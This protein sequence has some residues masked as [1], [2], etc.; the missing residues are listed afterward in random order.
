MNT[1]Q[2]ELTI[3]ALE[4]AREALAGELGQSEVK[5]AILTIRLRLT[6]LKS[7][8]AESDTQEQIKL[9]A[10]IEALQMAEGAISDPR[11]TDL[12]RTLAFN[13][14]E[15]RIWQLRRETRLSQGA[16]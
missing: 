16:A 1:R 10:L 7:D 13:L 15:L 12:E 4:A 5:L 14:I 3:S 9:A 11:I 8:A 2:T 6:S